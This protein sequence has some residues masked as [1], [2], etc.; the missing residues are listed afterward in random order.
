[1][2]YLLVFLGAG[3]GGLFR[4]VVSSGVQNLG[5]GWIFPVGTMTVNILGCFLIGVGAQFSET[6]AF[7][8]PE[9]RAFLL[10]GI[11]G[12]FTTFSTFGYETFQLMRDGQ[13]LYAVLNAVL[14]VVVGILCV[15]LGYW[16]ARLL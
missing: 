10:I 5:N 6:R 11:L 14:Q 16:L 2:T 12:G 4:F 8:S 13:I 9:V 7:F 3:L 15:Y 1:M